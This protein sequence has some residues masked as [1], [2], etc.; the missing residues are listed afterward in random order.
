MG[1]LNKFIGGMIGLALG[2]PLG[3]IAGVAFA[4]VIDKAGRIQERTNPL[5]QQQQLF[6]V[7]AFSLL[8]YVASAD[9][10][11]T[12]TER[13]KV[14]EFIRRDLRL[15]YQTEELALRV[16]DAALNS[17]QSVEAVASQFYQGYRN[18]P[19][20]L[21]LM[22]DICYRVA[23]ADGTI[24]SKEEALILKIARLFHF[25]EP[26][27]ETFQKRYGL[28]TTSLEQAYATL[29]LSSGATNEE[30]KR[31]YRKLSMEYHPDTL[32]SKGLGEEFLKA[33]TEKF[34]AIQDAYTRIKQE[35][36]L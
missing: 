24:S 8:A 33:A 28:A 17:N 23:Y 26:L 27:I 20:I 21:Q 2:G 11:V 18:N 35:R 30:I 36:N 6:F 5:D 13:Q 4:S 25:S 34:R 19:A 9:G 10:S 29:G 14:V 15:D 7:G 32:I 31:A 3:M 22:V 12:A 16:F 1:W